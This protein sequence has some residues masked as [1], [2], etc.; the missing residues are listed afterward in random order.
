MVVVSKSEVVP[1]P[2][3]SPRFE[4]QQ[5]S[6]LVRIARSSLI[7]VVIQRNL[8]QAHFTQPINLW[9]TLSQESSCIVVEMEVAMASYK[10]QD[11]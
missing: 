4:V 3:A 10:D 5:A 11:G 7:L 2:A 6:L 9:A 8:S 1:I